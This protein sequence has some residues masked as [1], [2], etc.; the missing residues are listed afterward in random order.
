MA[1]LKRF[2]EDSLP[3]KKLGEIASKERPANRKT[4]SALHQWWARRPLTLS[5]AIILSCA[6]LAPQTEKDRI[7]YHNL[8]EQI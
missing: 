3:L 6:V 4:L 5:R 8:L 2:I 1:Y 7:E